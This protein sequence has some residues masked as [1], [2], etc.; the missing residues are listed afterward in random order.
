MQVVPGLCC[1][2]MWMRVNVLI[3]WGLGSLGFLRCSLSLNHQ[4]YELQFWQRLFTLKGMTVLQGGS[5]KNGGI[6]NAN[7]TSSDLC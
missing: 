4:C 6:E 5:G 2:L 7:V 1:A 3:S